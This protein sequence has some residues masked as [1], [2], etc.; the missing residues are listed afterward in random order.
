MPEATQ[1]P[2]AIIRAEFGKKCDATTT[3]LKTSIKQIPEFKEAL[4]TDFFEN[5]FPQQKPTGVT[6]SYNE[7]TYQVEYEI[8]QD[9]TGEARTIL[10]LI[11]NP[12]LGQNHQFR[13]KIITY[14]RN[15]SGKFGK[16]YNGLASMDFFDDGRP[17]SF[18]G[19]EALNKT[20]EL[21]PEFFPQPDNPVI[22]QSA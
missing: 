20:R 17:K 6:F 8:F 14:Y 12:E 13:L 2:E 1:T 7:F 15:D 22:P 11:K 19:Q 16:P 18:S 9:A 10:K 21:F 5:K 3:L 4:S